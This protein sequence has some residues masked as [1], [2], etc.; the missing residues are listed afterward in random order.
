MV[1]FS[2]LEDLEDFY[3][4][5]PTKE[6]QLEKITGVAE[7]INSRATSFGN[8]YAL[9]VN[10]TNYSTGKDNPSTKYGIEKG[11]TVTFSAEQNAKGYWDI[12]GPVKKQEPA[13]PVVESGSPAGVVRTA[14]VAR[15]T[16]DIKQRTISRQAARNTAVEFLQLAQAAGVLPLAKT[17][18]ANFDLLRDHLDKLTDEF[19]NDSL[20]P[21]PYDA[22][23]I[24]AKS[25][26]ELAA[27]G[28]SKWKE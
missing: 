10:G 3:K 12:K 14:V 15:Q 5:K 24:A 27:A 13:A 2:D 26:D 20:N 21:K 6:N 8:M 17:K 25:G 18:G 11:D 28:D 16:E 9:K 4:K 23:P 7:Y 1:D 22:T 19:Y